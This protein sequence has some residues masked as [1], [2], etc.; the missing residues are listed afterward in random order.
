MTRYEAEKNLTS[1]KAQQLLRSFEPFVR[2][3]KLID[4]IRKYRERRDQLE[5]FQ[6]KHCGKPMISIQLKIL[7]G[8][9]LLSHVSMAY[10]R[11]IYEPENW[12]FFQFGLGEN[13]SNW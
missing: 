4:D 8:T 3:K 2:A 11:Y 12:N 5:N 6:R 1:E 13:P 10:V 7:T 9:I